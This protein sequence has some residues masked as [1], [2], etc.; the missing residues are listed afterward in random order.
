MR[1]RACAVAP[2][3][4]PRPTHPTRRP[5]FALPPPQ[6]WDVADHR[7]VRRTYLGHTAAV[8]QV[9]FGGDGREFLSC[10]YDKVARVWDTETGACVGAFAGDKVPLCA[11]WYPLDANIFLVGSASR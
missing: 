9:T 2:P 1:A 6:I 4:P 11:T 3:A 7:R 10:S 5:P 8:R